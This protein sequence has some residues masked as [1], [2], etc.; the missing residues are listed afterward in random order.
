[1]ELIEFRSALATEAVTGA[2]ESRQVTFVGR[3]NENTPAEFLYPAIASIGYPN[4]SDLISGPDH[5]V[6]SAVE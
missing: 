4:G 2:C 3:I 1:M 5:F 6:E